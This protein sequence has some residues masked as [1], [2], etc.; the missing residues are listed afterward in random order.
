MVHAAQRVLVGMSIGVLA[1]GACHGPA[2]TTLTLSVA[3][4][5]T[6]TIGEIETQYRQAHGSVDF[7][8]N[9][10]GSGMLEKY[11]NL[12][13]Y[14]ARGEARPAFK[15]AFADQLAVFTAKPR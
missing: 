1:L 2:R 4:S 15:R 3:A 11:S 7:R 14:V 6:Q 10:G 12:A 9:F 5:L 13:A 8:N